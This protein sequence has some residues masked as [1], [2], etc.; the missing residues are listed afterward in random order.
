MNGKPGLFI[1]NHKPPL[2]K[3]DPLGELD[4][5]LGSGKQVTTL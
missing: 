5:C 2:S 3:D 4:W 1:P